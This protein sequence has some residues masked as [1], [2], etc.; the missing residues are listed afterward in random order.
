MITWLLMFGNPREVQEFIRY[1]YGV[2][3]SLSSISSGI[4]KGNKM[5]RIPDEVLRE[6]FPKRL[7]RSLASDRVYSHLKQMIV[8]GKLRKGQRIIRE[9]IAQDL[10]VSENAVSVTFSK[11]KRDGLIIIKHGAGSFV[12]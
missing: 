9:K 5:A 4:E 7:G 10:E 8:S 6:V 3:L 12:A 11:L 1:F 2:K